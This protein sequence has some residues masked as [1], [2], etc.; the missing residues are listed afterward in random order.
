MG[1]IDEQLQTSRELLLQHIGDC[2]YI[3]YPNGTVNDIFA[4]AV[5]RVKAAHY[6][7]G[8]TT[9]EGETESDANPFVLPRIGSSTEDIH[10][11]MFIVN[12]SARRNGAY[13]SWVK[14]SFTA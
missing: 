5:S 7:A 3:A 11:F 12:M 4:G 9:V 13:R 14:S 10:H 1:E 6:S 8:L 2:K